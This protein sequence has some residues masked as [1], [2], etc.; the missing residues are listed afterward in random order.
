MSTTKKLRRRVVVLE[1]YIEYLETKVPNRYTKD[2]DVFY[3]QCVKNT[4][5]KVIDKYFRRNKNVK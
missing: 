4:V 3:R 5:N 1:N 2:P